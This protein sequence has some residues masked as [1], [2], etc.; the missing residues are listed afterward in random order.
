MQ[1]NCLCCGEVFKVK[2]SG[3][4]CYNCKFNPM[5]VISVTNIKKEFSLSENILIYNKLFSY[6]FVSNR[7]YFKIRGT[8][9]L[10]KDIE[11]LAEI[12]YDD[13][14]ILDSNKRKYGRHKDFI[15]RRIKLRGLL[16][17]LFFSGNRYHKYIGDDCQGYLLNNCP[18]FCS[19]SL[20]LGVMYQSEILQC[21]TFKQNK[22][23]VVD[24]KT[25][26]M[27]AFNKLFNNDLKMGSI[28]LRS[29][30]YE[31]YFKNGGSSKNAVK[32]F[33]LEYDMYMELRDKI[34]LLDVDVQDNMRKLAVYDIESFLDKLGGGEFKENIHMGVSDVKRALINNKVIKA[35]YDLGMFGS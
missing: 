4:L 5:Y 18:D 34:H 32:M 22:L 9:Y 10:L 20:K 12:V 14:S 19:L 16:E 29:L 6:E 8:R 27:R 11:E 13:A 26:F 1:S 2:I 17:E 23:A 25:K 3:K 21:V 24:R 15:L 30:S 28:G 7:G 35:D 31:L 33:K